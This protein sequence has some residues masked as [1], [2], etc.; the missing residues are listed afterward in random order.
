MFF[1]KLGTIINRKTVITAA[2]CIL[3]TFEYRYGNKSY[4]INVTEN[5]FYPTIGS[6]YTVYVGVD[7]IITYD[8]DIKPAKA[9]TVD[10]I[11]RVILFYKNN[12]VNFLLF[13]LLAKSTRSMRIQ[14]R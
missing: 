12:L 5:S 10:R 2:H 3:E 1:L 13:L 8:V 9:V 7:K 6:L 14:V 4:L 11:I